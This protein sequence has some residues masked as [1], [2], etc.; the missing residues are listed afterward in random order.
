MNI[1][2]LVTFISLTV[3]SVNSSIVDT[4]DV[5]LNSEKIFCI[6]LNQGEKAKG[7]FSVAETYGI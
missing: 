6:N 1:L 3:S 5:K 2:L 7:S 4:V